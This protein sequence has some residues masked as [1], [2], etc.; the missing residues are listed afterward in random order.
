MED[1][2]YRFAIRDINDGAIH[3]SRYSCL[4]DAMSAA[5]ELAYE[6]E[7]ELDEFEVV[8]LKLT[9]RGWCLMTASRV[10]L[11]MCVKWG[12][13]DVGHHCRYFNVFDVGS[14]YEPLLQNEEEEGA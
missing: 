4:D 11:S 3:R 14:G 7:M 9:R 2:E 6:L 13:C 10:V 8:E 1:M 5:E 12:G